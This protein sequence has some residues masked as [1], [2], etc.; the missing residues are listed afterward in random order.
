MEAVTRNLATG[1]PDADHGITAKIVPLKQEMVGSVRPVLTVLLA[2]V[3]FVLLIACANVG[4]LL[5][6]RSTGRMRELAVRATLGASRS[7]VVR[8]L[9]TESV[10]LA[11]GG[12]T[13]G[14]I[15]ATWGTRLALAA[16]PAALPRAEQIGIDLHVLVFSAVI[17]MLSAVFFGLIP[18][19]KVSQPNLNERLKQG[20]RG[21]SGLRHRAQGTFGGLRIAV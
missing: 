17:S 2:A 16:L 11:L 12:G 7:R 10:L 3:G 15:L 1:F 13:F 5:L 18:A 6:A 20:G 21:A 8:Q 19:F 4:N 14:L 9:L